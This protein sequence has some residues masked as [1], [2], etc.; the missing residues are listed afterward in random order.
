M[1]AVIL[2]L[3]SSPIIGQQQI[4]VKT[5]DN[6]PLQCLYP[7]GGNIKLLEWKRSDLKEKR[8][9]FYF[10]GKPLYK[11]YQHSTFRGRV[12][13]KD[14]Q[15]KNGNASVILKKVTVNDTGTYECRA[16]NGGRPELISI[17]DL[18][19]TDSGECVCVCVEAASCLSV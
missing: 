13:L 14:P 16:A 8:F 4:T 18:T 12:E 7:R 3:L 5:G 11:P 19:V 6:V 10:R 17:I 15:M 1:A 9:I 2:L